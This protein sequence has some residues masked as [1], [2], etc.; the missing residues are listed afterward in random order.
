MNYSKKREEV[1]KK[2]AE[3]G[4]EVVEVK[5]YLIRQKGGRDEGA[6]RKTLDDVDCY[7]EAKK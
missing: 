4:L 1:N 2:A 6:V 3:L 7:L 5:G